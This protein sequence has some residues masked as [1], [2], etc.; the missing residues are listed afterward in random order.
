MKA[1]ACGAIIVLLI[2][3]NVAVFGRV[4]TFDFVNYD[5]PKYVVENPHVQTGL[6]LENAKAALT[7][8]FVS[9]WYPLTMLSHMLDVQLAGL[10]AA[11]HHLTNLILHIANTILVFIVLRRLTG[12][13]VRSAA[14][15][16]LFGIHAQ[17]V[18]AVAWIASRKDVLS[19]LFW[20]LALWAYAAY[21]QRRGLRR[22]VVLCAAS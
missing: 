10:D 8:S 17:N 18:E 3:A 12:A 21:V 6:T 19:T 13:Q 5:D 14:V 15:A 9:G 7:E 11:A 16:I 4:A 22:Y 1:R 2:A 20:W